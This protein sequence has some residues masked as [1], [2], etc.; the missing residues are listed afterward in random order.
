MTQSEYRVMLH[1][2][3]AEYGDYL[4][5]L[6]SKLGPVLDFIRHPWPSEC[7]VPLPQLRTGNLLHHERGEAVLG[8][9]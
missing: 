4:R 8:L 7:G 3:D 2:M 5:D 6:S 9:L 1:R